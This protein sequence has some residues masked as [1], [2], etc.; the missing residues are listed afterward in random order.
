MKKTVFPFVLL[1]G[2][3]VFA[4]ATVSRTLVRQQWPWHGQVRVDFELA[5]VTS[6]VDI[7]VSATADGVALDAAA[8]Q[9]LVTGERFALQNGRHSL[10]F[11]PAALIPSRKAGDFR[12]TLTPVASDAS[13][14]EVLYKIIDLTTGTVEDVSVG[15]LLSG[16]YGSVRCPDEPVAVG[17]AVTT[18]SYVW[19]GVTNDVKY[20]TDY[21]V[22]RKI[23]AKGATWKTG[24]GTK[25]SPAYVIAP[26]T[27]DFYAGVFETTQ[28]QWKKLMG[29]YPKSQYNG[30]GVRDRRPAETV[31]YDS[32]VRGTALYPAKP[33][34]ETFLGRLNR[35]TGLDCDLPAEFQWEWAAMAGTGHL[36]S[37]YNTNG[38]E[39]PGRYSGNGGKPDGALPARECGPAFGTA[40]V[41]SYEASQWGLYDCHGNV[42][43]YCL[44]W[45][46]S[47]ADGSGT[48]VEA[49]VNLEGRVNVNFDQ[50]DQ[51]ARGVNGFSRLSRGGCNE[52][53]SVFVI[54]SIGY[55][56]NTG[57]RKLGFRV[58][59]NVFDK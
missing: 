29:D 50:P 21:L 51:Q 40:Y 33:S 49:R 58:F 1:A 57:F 17:G 3:S 46:C 25:A 10:S 48:D 41:G 35:L 52:D 36:T 56:P 26:L 6:P 34:G 28:G 5:G 12:V 31:A 38:S 15:A 42:Y 20:V 22:L 13:M 18:A 30:E 8:L 55:G 45:W 27:N 44:D 11:D 9:P 2:L 43:E 24:H 16:R 47:Q 37:G 4:E 19:T 54:S 7:V 53:D 32:E 39:V 14:A 59:L 23:W